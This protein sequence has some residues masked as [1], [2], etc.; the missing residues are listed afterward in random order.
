LEIYARFAQLCD[1]SELINYDNETAKLIES[2]F[3]VMC[4]LKSATTR[5]VIKLHLVNI[6]YSFKFPVEVGVEEIKN[7][8][9]KK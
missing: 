6:G 9:R 5:S 7:T 4:N 3:T 1:L 8:Q 2:T